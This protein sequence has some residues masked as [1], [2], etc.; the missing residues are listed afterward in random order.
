[1]KREKNCAKQ[2][3]NLAQPNEK[4]HDFA[5]L[6]V[7]LIIA[8]TLMIVLCCSSCATSQKVTQATMQTDVLMTKDSVNEQVFLL[9]TVTVPQSQVTLEIPIDSLLKLPKNAEYRAKNGQAS[10]QVR[11]NKD[12]VYVYATCDSLQRLCKYYEKQT[13]LYKRAY[14]R[15]LNTVQ[16]VEEKHSNPIRTVLIS[17]I[18][19]VIIGILITIIIK[20]K[21]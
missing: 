18:V 4:W 15:A 9:E 6:S 8:S 5:K 21:M 12:T 16:T 13:A 17:F 20:L 7:W 1:M 2:K 14:E 19:G 11:F 10:A 3:K